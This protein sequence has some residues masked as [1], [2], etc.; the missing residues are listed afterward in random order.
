MSELG[1]AGATTAQT[2][3]YYDPHG[4]FS[5]V[6]SAADIYDT[7]NTMSQS[8]QNL[9]TPPLAGSL[10][11]CLSSCISHALLPFCAPA[12]RLLKHGFDVFDSRVSVA[13]SRENTTFWGFLF[14]FIHLVNTLVYMKL[15]FMV[16]CQSA[17]TTVK[18][19]L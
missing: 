7:I 12:M 3:G 8:G 17:V 5:G 4:G 18:I 16:M 6:T 10:G 19:N 1:G 11:K 14:C 15:I 9:Y 2:G 13:T